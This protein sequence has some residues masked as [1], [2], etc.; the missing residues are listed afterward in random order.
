MEKNIADLLHER[1]L[2][3]SQ[4]E[5][6]IYG[7][8]EIRNN[9]GKEYIYVHKR[10]DGIK[11][12]QYVGEM[13]NVLV[14]VI[15]ENNILAKQFKKRI[16]EINK[17]LDNLAYDTIQLADDVLVN[18]A[19][20]RRYMVDSIYKQAM[21]EGVATTYSDTETIVNGGKVSNMTATDIT[22][23]VNLKRAWEFILDDGVISYPTN[24]A[25]LC[26]INQIVE[27][28]FSAVAGKLRSVPVSIG[29]S[30]YLPPM[31]IEFVVKEELSDLLNS[32]LSVIDKTIEIKD[33][34]RTYLLNEDTGDTLDANQMKQAV[35][36][37]Y[38]LGKGGYIYINRIGNTIRSLHY[39][40]EEEISFLTNEDPIFKDYN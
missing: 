14:N 31:P 20:A 32:E 25:V 26:Q 19:L 23:V 18:V 9:N 13:S 12:S 10:I 34:Y 40:D 35:V 22:K 3:S 21:L 6:M 39:V 4:L 15:T 29:K 16:K 2:I 1:E 36:R 28:G 7:S 27:D 17:M 30:T 38:F 5:K 37:D 24:Y 11:K 33:D 8:I